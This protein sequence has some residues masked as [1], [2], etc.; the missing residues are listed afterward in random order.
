MWYRGAICVIYVVWTAEEGEVIDVREKRRAL[1]GLN[2][3]L[4]KIVG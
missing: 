3:N 2:G 1:R 4:I